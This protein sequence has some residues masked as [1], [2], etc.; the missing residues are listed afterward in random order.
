[1]AATPTHTGK[2]RLGIVGIGNCASALIQ[3]LAYYRDVRSNEPSPGL[4]TASIGGY[5]AGDVE[6]AAA[7][8]ISSRK[9]GRDVSQAVWADP[10]NTLRFVLER[11]L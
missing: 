1:M 9:A 7:F 5:Q 10:N 11:A 4:M 3:G 8:D 6:I 2:V